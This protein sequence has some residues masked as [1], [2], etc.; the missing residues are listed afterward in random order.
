MSFYHNLQWNLRRKSFIY[1]SHQYMYLLVIIFN[2]PN[3]LSC[4]MYYHIIAVLLFILLYW[5]HSKWYIFIYYSNIW[6]VYCVLC[7]LYCVCINRQSVQLN[8]TANSI[9]HFLAFSFLFS[10]LAILLISLP[11][12]HNHSFAQI[13]AYSSLYRYQLY[14]SMYRL[15]IGVSVPTVLSASSSLSLSSRSL[16]RQLSHHYS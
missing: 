14:Y 2:R 9:S 7:R 12:T 11:L 16:S 3:R 1:L 13:D 15:F 6:N 4:T 10:S 5:F 8:N